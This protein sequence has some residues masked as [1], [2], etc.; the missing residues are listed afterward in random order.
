MKV[1]ILVDKCIHTCPFYKSDR[2]RKMYCDH[3]VFEYMAGEDKAIQ[4]PRI[5]WQEHKGRVPSTCPL[6]YRPVNTHVSLK[7]S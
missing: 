5:N 3:P 4:L 1:I 6:Q 7:P 2:V